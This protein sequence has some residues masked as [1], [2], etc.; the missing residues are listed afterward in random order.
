MT[1]MLEQILQLVQGQ[2]EVG[3]HLPELP[4]GELDPIVVAERHGA[5]TNL[6]DD[7]RA[8]LAQLAEALLQ[9]SL[10]LSSLTRHVLVPSMMNITTI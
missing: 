3:G 7:V 10:D 6:E 2:A 8:A 1:V 9:T 5:G 4:V